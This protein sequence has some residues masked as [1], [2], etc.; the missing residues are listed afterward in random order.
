MVSSILIY[1][2]N[3]RVLSSFDEPKRIPYLL[4]NYPEMFTS[5]PKWCSYSHYPNDEDSNILVYIQMW[6]FRPNLMHKLT[7]AFNLCVISTIRKTHRYMKSHKEVHLRKHMGNISPIFNPFLVGPSISL[8]LKQAYTIVHHANLGERVKHNGLIVRSFVGCTVDQCDW[9]MISK[10]RYQNDIYILLWLSSKGGKA[11]LNT[12]CEYICICIY[13]CTYSYNHQ[14]SKTWPLY[15]LFQSFCP[16][17]GD[18]WWRCAP[19][20]RTLRFHGQGKGVAPPRI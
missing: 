20:T 3:S 18:R 10:K 11:T 12:L 19:H 14:W 5:I 4:W 13:V 16:D 6:I 7:K 9:Q 1:N 15:K 2:V 17:L 8:Y